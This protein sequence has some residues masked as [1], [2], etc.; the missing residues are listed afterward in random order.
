MAGLTTKLQ[1]SRKLN[2]QFSQVS[3]NWPPV[4]VNTISLEHSFARHLY[5]IYGCFPTTMAEL[6]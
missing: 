5:I 3:M 6:S 4:S 2:N 1:N